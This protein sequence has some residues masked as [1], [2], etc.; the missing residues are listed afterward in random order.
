MS[1]NHGRNMWLRMSVMCAQ[2]VRSAPGVS[3]P[4]VGKIAGKGPTPPANAI[5]M[6]IPN[7]NSG[8]A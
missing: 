4:P 7:Q 8:I 6:R 5:S 2:P 1:T 3:Y